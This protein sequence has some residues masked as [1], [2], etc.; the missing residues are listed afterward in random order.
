MSYCGWVEEKKA[1]RMSCCS[2]MGGWVGGWVTYVDDGGGEESSHI[3]LAL[4]GGGG[5]GLV[6]AAQGHAVFAWRGE[7]S[8]WVGGWVG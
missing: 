2:P 6:H 8:G 5:R 4:E 3:D 1:V 7:V